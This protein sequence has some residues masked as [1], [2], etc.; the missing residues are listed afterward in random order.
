VQNQVRLR[1]LNHTLRRRLTAYPR[2]KAK[3]ICVENPTCTR[4][5]NKTT[6]FRSSSSHAL[7]LGSP[8]HHTIPLALVSLPPKP[9]ASLADKMLKSIESRSH[10]LSSSRRP[11]CFLPTIR[12]AYDL[13]QRHASSHSWSSNPSDVHV[14]RLRC[15]SGDDHHE[16]YVENSCRGRMNGPRGGGHRGVCEV[17]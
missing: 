14:C 12:S 3:G 10:H 4:V 9:I 8:S 13:H 5:H 6:H 7:H 1:L 11:N 17:G 2:Y 16:Y 15:R